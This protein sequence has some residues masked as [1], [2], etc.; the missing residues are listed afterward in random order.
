VTIVPE[1]E[2]RIVE[3]GGVENQYVEKGHL[4]FRLDDTQYQVRGAQAQAEV[5]SA[6]LDVERLKGGLRQVRVRSTGG[7]PGAEL[8]ADTFDRQD[9][10]QKRGVV[11][12]SVSTK[13]G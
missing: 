11:A 10:L 9:A 13:R 8:R 12:Q 7:R 1:I 6:R 4:L 5:A 2:G 3:V